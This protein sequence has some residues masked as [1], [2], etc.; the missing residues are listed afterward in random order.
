MKKIFLLLFLFPLTFSVHAQNNNV[1]PP[2]PGDSAHILQKM[3]RFNGDLKKYLVKH[4]K[5]PKAERFANITGTVYVSFIIE[6]DG[7]VSNVHIIKG[8]PNGPG[9]DSEAVKIVRD[10]PKWEPGIQNDGPVRVRFNLPIHFELEDHNRRVYTMVD[11][12]PRFNGD[13]MQYLANNIKYPE[14]EKDANITG[15]VYIGFI[16]E[17]NGKVKHVKVLRGVAGGP[18]LDAEAV[19]VVKHMPRWMPGTLKGTIVRVRY[20]LPV[21]F[22]LN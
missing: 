4:I 10:M 18:G 14:K 15:T 22:K 17:K 3:P 7:S 11:E 6:K 20:T 5:Y 1:P 19:K 12:M 2:P 9:L 8:V 13:I 16:V 21:S